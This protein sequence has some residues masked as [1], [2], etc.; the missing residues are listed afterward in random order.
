MKVEQTDRDAAFNLAVQ[1]C[2]CAN[3]E[4]RKSDVA[5]LLAYAEAAEQRGREA[6]RAE[7]VA[8]LNDQYVA[9]QDRKWMGPLNIADAIEARQHKEPTQ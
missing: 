8:W 4:Q 2:G 5:A 7:V 1:I 9:K 3:D 6:E